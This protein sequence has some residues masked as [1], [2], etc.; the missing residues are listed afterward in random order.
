LAKKTD[1]K[2]VAAIAGGNTLIGRE[3]QELVEDQ[4]LPFSLELL[5]GEMTGGTLAVRED[6]ALFLP[7]LTRETLDNVKVVF[8]AGLPTSHFEAL[9]TAPKDAMMIDLTGALAAEPGA[10]LRAP[11]VEARKPKNVKITV[12]AHPAAIALRQLLQLLSVSGSIERSVIVIYEPASERGHPGIGELDKQ[13][14]ALLALQAVPESVYDA[15]LA[16]NLLPEY[17]SEAPVKLEVVERRIEE[18]LASLLKESSSAIP[19][20]SLN[21]VQA[22]V[23]HGYS[24]SLWV[25][26]T[27]PADPVNIATV[28]RAAKVDVRDGDTA[29]ASNVGTA[30]Q[31]GLTVG[32]IKRDRAR[33]NAVW[34]WM[35]CDNL[36]VLGENALAAAQEAL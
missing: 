15:Q 27:T 3:I 20:P 1:T 36:R 25:E 22:P 9:K 11:L 12:I 4:K 5:D 33:P 30:Q 18:H 32:S 28:L 10:V 23:F 26:F 6:E 19:M 35:V 14:R 8:L 17:G 7:P 29:P 13:T 31:S 16:F 21:L 2:T 34:L 24:F